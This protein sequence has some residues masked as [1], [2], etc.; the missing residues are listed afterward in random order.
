MVAAPTETLVLL[1]SLRLLV[2]LLPLPST[3]RAGLAQFC[4]PADT[5]LCIK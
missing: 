3:A 1:Y 2:C 5:Y 4:M